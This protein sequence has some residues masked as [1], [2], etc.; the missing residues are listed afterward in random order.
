MIPRRILLV[1]LN[2]LID[3]WLATSSLHVKLGLQSILF[4]R[5]NQ[6]AVLAG[7]AI[8]VNTTGHQALRA[9]WSGYPFVSVIRAL[10]D[11]LVLEADP[12]CCD[13]L[14]VRESRELHLAFS[15][16][17]EW[18]RGVVICRWHG[19]WDWVKVSFGWLETTSVYEMFELYLI[20]C[21]LED[22]PRS[23]WFVT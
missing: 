5:M 22:D 21:V 12:V 19:F 7:L 4:L 23:E 3:P 20:D 10:V 11:V 9:A 6:W 2:R 13:I 16:G 1:P 17:L 15:W 8:R 14:G 18:G